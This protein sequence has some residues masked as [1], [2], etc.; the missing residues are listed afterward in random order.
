G[1]QATQASLYGL[2][3]VASRKAPV[4]RTLGNRIEHLGGNDRVADLTLLQPIPDHPL[5]GP[6]T[7]AVRRVKVVDARVPGVVHKGEGRLFVLP[8]P[9]QLR[10]R[11]NPAESPAAEPQHRDTHPGPPQRAV[12]HCASAEMVKVLP[13]LSSAGHAGTASGAPAPGT[14]DR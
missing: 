4:H 12:L 6:A 7:I 9:E 2:H 5:G 3:D 13:L 11:T 1:L 14:G 10:G 8:L